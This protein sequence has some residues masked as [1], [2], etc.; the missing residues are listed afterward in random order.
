MTQALTIRD[1]HSQAVTLF[2][3]DDPDAIVEA[4]TR[5]AKALARVIDDRHLYA[6]IQNRKHVL[7]E[8][9]TLLGSMSGVFPHCV[10]SRP[11]DDGSGWEA[12][13]EAQTLSGAVVGSAE[14]SCS[15]DEPRWRTQPD[16]ALRSM[17]QTRATG[18]ALR[19]PLGFIISLAGYDATPQEEMSDIGPRAERPRAQAPRRQRQSGAPGNIEGPHDGPD[20][21]AFW[22]QMRAIGLKSTHIHAAA[23]T[24]SVQNWSKADLAQLITDIGD[25]TG[26]DDF[27]R[28][29]EASR[30]A[31]M[32]TAKAWRERQPV[33]DE[34]GVIEGEA[35]E[36]AAEEES[37]E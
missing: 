25:A 37:F 36:V 23:G 15:R 31:A 18:K 33:A 22:A 1:G 4:A 29:S 10:W 35:T 34:D 7:I 14:A 26:L 32:E 16:Y 13:V 30:M 9:W 12:R 24:D 17:A 3:T 27:T 8:G 28:M 21:T 11:L 19:L 5:R 6:E 2:G 20:W